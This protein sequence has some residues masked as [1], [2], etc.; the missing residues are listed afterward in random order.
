MQV[1]LDR[2]A[3]KHAMEDP[4]LKEQV[5]T[6]HRRARNDLGVQGLPFFVMKLKGA[7]A[8][9]PRSFDHQAPTSCLVECIDSLIAEHGTG[10]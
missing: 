10:S 2:D 9:K 7:E 5:W 4:A 6:E 1:G 3:C 8:V